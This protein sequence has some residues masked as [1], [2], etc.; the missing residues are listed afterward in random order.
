MERVDLHIQPRARLTGFVWRG[1]IAVGSECG[2]IRLAS[3]CSP[4]IIAVFV[5]FAL[6]AEDKVRFWGQCV[7]PI[8]AI[9]LLDSGE[10]CKS[11]LTRCC[12]VNGHDL[13]F[14]LL[15]L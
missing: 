3:A 12:R 13:V 11:A 8:L 7:L 14:V 15:E 6:K 2:P 1:L 5:A 10:H 9:I 4:R